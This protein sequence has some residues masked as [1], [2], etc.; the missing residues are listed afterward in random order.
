M[1]GFLIFGILIK[2]L[3]IPPIIDVD[4]VGQIFNWRKFFGRL[5]AAC[6]GAVGQWTPIRETHMDVMRESPSIRFAAIVDAT[7]GRPPI[8]TSVA[9]VYRH[10]FCHTPPQRGVELCGERFHRYLVLFPFVATPAAEFRRI[11]PRISSNGLL[12]DYQFGLL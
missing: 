8:L 9:I 11:S 5:N 7:I 4:G 3:I 10:Y 1:F 6:W 2:W 12:C